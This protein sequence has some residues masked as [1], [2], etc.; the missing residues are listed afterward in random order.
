MD[1][2]R[3]PFLPLFSGISSFAFV[4]KDTRAPVFFFTPAEGILIIS[5]VR[6]CEFQLSRI[7]FVRVCVLRIGKFLIFRNFYKIYF[8]LLKTVWFYAWIS[9]LVSKDT[10]KMFHLQLTQTRIEVILKLSSMFTRYRAMF[11]NNC[12]YYTTWYMIPML[13]AIIW[14]ERNSNFI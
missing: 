8:Q 12:M 6:Y 7:F 11:Y 13:L 1:L 9:L 3:C 2:D 14:N 5:F 4:T 10:M